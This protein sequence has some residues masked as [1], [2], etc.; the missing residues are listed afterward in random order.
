LSVAYFTFIEGQIGFTQEA[1]V[2]FRSEESARLCRYRPQVVINKIAEDPQKIC[3]FRH[4]TQMPP[5]QLTLAHI[6]AS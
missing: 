6:I 1:V 2:L 5:L 4:K 3:R